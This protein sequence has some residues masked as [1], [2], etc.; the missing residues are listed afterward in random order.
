MPVPQT[1]GLL[2]VPASPFGI[3]GFSFPEQAHPPT[4]SRVSTSALGPP[5]PNKAASQEQVQSAATDIK[6]RADRTR[7]GPKDGPLAPLAWFLPK[8]NRE[9]NIKTG[10]G[11]V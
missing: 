1:A 2:P 10:A 4:L 3:V 6:S 8:R 9:L 5:T 7:R 11:W